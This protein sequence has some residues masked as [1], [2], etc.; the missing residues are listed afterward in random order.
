MAVQR[1]INTGQHVIFR[2]RI[3]VTDPA[4]LQQSS[5]R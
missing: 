3:P 2:S 4:Q 5:F 1:K